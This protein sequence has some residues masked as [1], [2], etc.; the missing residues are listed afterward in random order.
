MINSLFKIYF[1]ITLGLCFA[2]KNLPSY[3]LTDSKGRPLD[4]KLVE[5]LNRKNG[6]F[7]EVGAY[8]G[9]CQSNTLLLEQHFNWK[10]LLIEANP[11][12]IE[13]I[14]KNRP[15]SIAYSCALG[16]FDQNYTYVYGD[17]QNQS[18]MCSIDGVRLNTTPLTKVSIR[19]LQSILDELH[20]HHID[21]FSLDVEGYEYNIL[22]GIDFDKTTFDYFLIEI[23]QK[24]YDKI[25]HFLR[26]RNYDL[27]ENFSGYNKVDN[28]SV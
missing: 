10:G 19:S 15:T 3:S 18:P 27:V 22:Q 6:F 7:I 13:S 12:L 23:Y 2:S 8:D 14:K 5:V 20:V 21:L 26:E 17:F 4:H 1:C 16:N 25:V 11:Y 9:V 24:D 28:P